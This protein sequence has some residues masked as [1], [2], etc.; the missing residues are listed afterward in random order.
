[1]MT[2]TSLNRLRSLAEGLDNVFTTP[3]DH[4]YGCYYLDDNGNVETILSGSTDPITRDAIVFL[5][6]ALKAV[7][8]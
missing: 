1:M 4:D 8:E 2:E 6:E 7:R 5:V 3:N